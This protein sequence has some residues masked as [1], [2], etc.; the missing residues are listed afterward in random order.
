MLFK[1]IS[2]LFRLMTSIHT[3]AQKQITW[4]DS[5]TSVNGQ[6]TAD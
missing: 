4:Y 1:S 3:A 5:P 6:S 2:K